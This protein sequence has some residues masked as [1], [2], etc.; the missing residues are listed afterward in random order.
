MDP[1]DILVLG[2]SG[3]VGRHLCNR[4]VAAGRSVTVPTRRRERAKH[5]ILLPTC[6]V[7]Q[8]DVFDESALD[9]LV[10]GRDAVVNLVGILHGSQT[11][12][13]R[14]HVDLTR[15]LLAACERHAVPRLLHMSALGADAAGPSMYQRSKGEAEALVRAAP[16]A[17]T[18]FRPSVIFGAEDRFLNLFAQL[19]AW[20]PVLP[21]GGANARFQPVW[22]ED[23]AQAMCNALDDERTSR[24]V[25]ELAGPHVYTLRELV[26][27]A[28]RAAGH[29]RPVMALPD[30]LAR[31]QAACTELAPGEPLLSRD[32]LD[33]MKR[34]NLPSTQPYQ[35]PAV[36]GVVPSSL[37][38]EAVPYL[39]R[40]GIHTHLDQFRA[41]A[42]R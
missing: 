27:F 23:V 8:A 21:I 11:A 25:Y 34:D 38:A 18:V 22:V 32:N 41:R 4:L 17:W 7:V 10:A 3:F 42:N 29:A 13:T 2:G 12:F 5:L 16:L 30:A 24:Q 39:S 40:R 14:T 15:R 1:R 26:R 19:A 33:S 36:L 28:A 35:F 9:R 20:F 6:E 31:L 37:E